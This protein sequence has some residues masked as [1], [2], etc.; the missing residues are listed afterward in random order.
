MIRSYCIQ[1]LSDNFKAGKIQKEIAGVDGVKNIKITE[2][3]KELDIELDTGRTAEIMERVVNI[4][5][6]ISNGCEI[7]YKFN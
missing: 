3:L 5:S 4:C 2:D 6:R 1:A 7:R